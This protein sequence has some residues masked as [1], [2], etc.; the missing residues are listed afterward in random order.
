MLSSK[1]ARLLRITIVSFVAI[2]SLLI[3]AVGFVSRAASEF[4]YT[5]GINYN[6]GQNSTTSVYETYNV[7]NNTSN[8]YL[9]SIKLSTPSADIENLKVYYTGGGS[10]PFTTQLVSQE[11]GG[12]KYDY[13]QINID[14]TTAKVGY[15]LRWGFVVEYQTKSLVENKGRANV[16]YIP[17]IASEN[18]DSYNV[19]LSVPDNFGP[20]HGF[21][22][23]P[24]ETSKQNGV[25]TYSFGP[26]DLVNNSLQLLFGNSTTYKANFVYPITNDSS[27]TKNYTITLPPNTA[28]QSVYLQSINPRPLKTTLDKEGNIIAYYTVGPKQSVEVKADV[29]ADVKYINYDLAK[30]GTMKDIPP[31]LVN[32]YT[33]PT[34]YWQSENADIQAKAKEL[35]KDKLTVAA[36]VEAINKYVIDT[37]EYNNEKIKYNIRQGALKSFQNPANVV[38]LEYSDLSIALLRASGIPARM[39]VGYGYSGDLKLSPSVSDS[40]HSWVEA[41]IPNVGWIN[42]DPT[43]GEKFNN[44]G[45]SDIDH[46][47]FAIWGADD[48]KP[49][50][51]AENGTDTNYQFEK[52]T[53]T[54]VQEI[55]TPSTDASLKV[56]KWVVL[57]FISV[58]QHEVKSPS[59]SATYNL[60]LLLEDSKGTQKKSL[61]ST[62]PSQ[63]LNGIQIL[64][65]LNFAGASMA[66]LKEQGSALTL[67]RAATTTNYLPLVLIILILSVIIVLAVVKLLN[68]RK[69]KLAK[70]AEIEK[71]HDQETKK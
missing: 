49:A 43:W 37:L 12:F 5:I 21:G 9:D 23:I 24:K 48:S 10:I 36:K 16:V 13:T 60:E 30:S 67:A 34:K 66:Y 58:L 55:P 42:L 56:T 50:P 35:T 14:F 40:L 39:P 54:Y 69:S 47:T 7:T 11:S 31:I 17:G 15:G 59:N 27:V 22:I 28:A 52:T 68:K 70:Q 46:L 6:V 71:V 38:C 62:A 3:A 8:K 63:K 41:Y 33:R 57:P 32:E 19:Q 61:G 26:A 18:R 44:Y 65:G 29:L 53:L 25:V 51:V 45:V 4:S 2:V 20:V 1:K 64:T